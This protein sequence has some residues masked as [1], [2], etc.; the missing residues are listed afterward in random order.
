MMSFYLS[1][2]VWTP[3]VTPDSVGGGC[4]GYS[5]ADL[6]S[7]IKTLGTR[8][9]S[10]V[11]GQRTAKNP[12]KWSCKWFKAVAGRV[13]IKVKNKN[14]HI[15]WL[16]LDALMNCTFVLLPQKLKRILWAGFRWHNSNPTDVGH[17]A[18]KLSFYPLFWI[19]V[20]KPWHLI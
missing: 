7:N 2:A 6:N 4:W 17:Q 14:I 16:F 5:E 8:H 1:A 18:W 9:S 10:P 12:H 19:I 11:Y 13:W 20:D 3:R 15:L